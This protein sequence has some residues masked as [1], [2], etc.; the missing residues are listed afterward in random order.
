MDQSAIRS[1]PVLRRNQIRQTNVP[2]PEIGIYYG[3]EDEDVN[4]RFVV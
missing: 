1:A 2:V 3:G 4:P